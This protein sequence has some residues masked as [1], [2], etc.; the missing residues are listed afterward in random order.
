[1]DELGSQKIESKEGTALTTV[2]YHGSKYQIK[3]TMGEERYP[4]L[5]LSKKSLENMNAIIVLS[6]TSRQVEKG[7]QNLPTNI[8]IFEYQNRTSPLSYLEEIQ[9]TLTRKSI[10]S[11]KR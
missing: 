1:M 5:S 9:K 11:L 6:P 4:S 3:D 8:L 7:N 2:H 10:H